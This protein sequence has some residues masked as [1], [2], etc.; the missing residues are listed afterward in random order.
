MKPMNLLNFKRPIL[1]IATCLL[2]AGCQPAATP[3]AQQYSYQPSVDP[4]SY[5]TLVSPHEVKGEDVTI[6]SNEGM[7]FIENANAGIGISIPSTWFVVESNDNSGFTIYPPTAENINLPTPG[8]TFAHINRTYDKY[9]PVIQT[10]YVVEYIQ[11]TNFEG[12]LYRDSEF[13][14]PFQNAYVE[15]PEQNGMLLITATYGPNQNL[16]P[17]LLQILNTL[18]LY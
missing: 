2:L 1:W 4:E 10:G 3:A 8:I 18:V 11:Y 6:N 12:S 5:L 13:A 9:N 14:I 16:L 7:T 17:V 15:I